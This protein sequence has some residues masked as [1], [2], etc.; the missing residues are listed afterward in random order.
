MDTSK[1][2]ILRTAMDDSKFS[3]GELEQLYHWFHEGHRQ[4]SVCVCVIEREMLIH[5]RESWDVS[6]FTN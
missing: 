4:V 1:K 2:T 6:K 3:R 5:A